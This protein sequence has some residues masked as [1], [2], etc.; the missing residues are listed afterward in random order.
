MWLT[1]FQDKIGLKADAVASGTEDLLGRQVGWVTASF[2]AGSDV[3]L[4]QVKPR[5]EWVVQSTINMAIWV[6]AILLFKAIHV[7]SREHVDDVAMATL[8]PH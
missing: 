4:S 3:K 5:K 6:K 2:W 8:L 7:K 1:Q